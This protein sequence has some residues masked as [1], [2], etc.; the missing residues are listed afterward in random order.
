MHLIL[1][2]SIPSFNDVIKADF[3]F[4]HIE[5]TVFKLL[6][7]SSNCNFHGNFIG[8][9]M[10]TVLLFYS[11]PVW[12]CFRKTLVRV[13]ML[14]RVDSVKELIASYLVSLILQ[15]IVKSFLMKII[16]KCCSAA[17]LVALSTCCK[18]IPRFAL[19][20]IAN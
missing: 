1:N 4:L 15:A 18:Y 12:L 17:F 11:F 7:T 14:E 20:F 5:K 2:S 19:H 3:C 13:C 6:L 8:W 16:Q 10:L 9:L